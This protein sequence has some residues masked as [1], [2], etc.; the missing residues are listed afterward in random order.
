LN[1]KRF[2]SKIFLSQIF[3]KFFFNLLKLK[4]LDLSRNN[5]KNFFIFE[6][7]KVYR[8]DPDPTV[9]F[10]SN[11]LKLQENNIY[12][13]KWI[14]S[15]HNVS[16]VDLSF[17]Y[18]EEFEVISNVNSANSFSETTFN[19]TFNNLESI[20]ITFNYLHPLDN[21]T[22]LLDH[23]PFFC[24]CRLHEVL[25]VS[26]SYGQFNLDF[27]DATCDGPDYMEGRSV[28]SLTR[29]DL[30]CSIDYCI[31]NCTCFYRKVD[32]S[33]W[34]NCAN[35][36]LKVFPDINNEEMS[37]LT[38][39]V[40]LKFDKIRLDFTNNLLE[41]LPI[42]K[43][44]KVNVFELI[45]R[46]NSIDEIIIENLGKDLRT[47]DL[48][49]NK[50]KFLTNQ[51]VEK[52]SGMEKVWLGG[53]PW[54][55][56]CSTIDFFVSIKLYKEIIIDYEDIYCDNLGK[57]F[58][59]LENFEVCFDNVVI[60]AIIAG[61]FGV[62]G[63]VIG[64]FYKF[65]KD[66]KIFLYAHDMCLW[67]VSED[68]LDEDKVYDAFICFAADDQPLV[69]DIIIDLEKEPNNFKC[70]VG[71]RDWPPGH[72]FAELVSFKFDQ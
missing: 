71:I 37:N 67:F 11:I 60:I 1:K 68:E 38:T 20:K 5:L 30:M 18:I 61:V 28:K 10:I 33:I 50:L 35:G 40:P 43:T 49:N 47:L 4:N 53:N 59:E 2:K 46:N 36:E 23:N 16:Y 8:L 62:L 42:I 51:V 39:S 26:E 48:R 13:L 31:V 64:I 21:Y 63:I 65:K 44:T 41:K 32:K 70:L 6:K 15:N 7:I 3:R 54:L 12:K 29:I 52:L 66:I 9:P 55:C 57:K 24:N 58:D 27:G 25:D 69:E 19:L 22:F 34:L 56:D 17:N 72:M 14:S 45:A